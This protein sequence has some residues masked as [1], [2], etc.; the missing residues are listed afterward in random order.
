MKLIEKIIS[1]PKEAKLAAKASCLGF[2][3]TELITLVTYQAAARG[4]DFAAFAYAT[5]AIAIALTSG[6]LA[7]RAYSMYKEIRE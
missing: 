2:L 3:A 6:K 5:G 1:M 4:D 7:K